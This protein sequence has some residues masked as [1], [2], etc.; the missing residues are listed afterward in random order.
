MVIPDRIQLV[1]ANVAAR[2][3]HLRRSDT[4]MP[5]RILPAATLERPTSVVR[6]LCEDDRTPS[7]EEIGCSK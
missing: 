1:I 4:N 3:A 6:R 2:T 5:L 7:K